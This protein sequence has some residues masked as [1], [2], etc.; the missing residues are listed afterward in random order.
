MKHKAYQKRCLDCSICGFGFYK[1]YMALGRGF[2]EC[3]HV[4]RL[5]GHDNAWSDL[6]L[7]CPNCHRMLH[8]RRPWLSADELI[9]I[10]ATQATDTLRS[11]FSRRARVGWTM[12]VEILMLPSEEDNNSP[13]S[14]E[15]LCIGH[16][17]LL[18]SDLEQR[19]MKYGQI[20]GSKRINELIHLCFEY[21]SES[22]EQKF[23]GRFGRLS[24]RW[25]NIA[26]RRQA[27][28]ANES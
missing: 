22:D 3:N 14:L 24:D 12:E 23:A 20:A 19:Y 2:I 5:Q 6:V 9:G 8:R 4:F 16:A 13:N 21:M 26:L 25:W 10:L 11:W 27:R 15:S 17:L 28:Q 7:V 1:T 18:R